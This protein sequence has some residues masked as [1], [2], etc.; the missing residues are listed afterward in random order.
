MAQ[1][2][3]YIAI[4]NDDLCLYQTVTPSQLFSQL[5]A[6][7]HVVYVYIS[8]LFISAAPEVADCCYIP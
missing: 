7:T 2:F 4:L 8:L 6:G 3:K 5:H 1:L